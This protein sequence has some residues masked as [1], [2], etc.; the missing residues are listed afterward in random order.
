VEVSSNAAGVHWDLTRIAVDAADVRRRL[1]LLRVQAERFADRYRG[2]IAGL[3][4]AEL[5]RALDALSALEE[6]SSEI[7]GYAGLREAADFEDTEAA[8][9]AVALEEANVWLLAAT[10][11]VGL[12]W[13]AVP[14][15]E[16][17]LTA[18]HPALSRYRYWLLA[19]RRFAP[20]TL[21]KAEERVFEER[22]AS[23]QSAW[24]TLHGR[25][26]AGIE[27]EFDAGEGP[28]LHTLDLL[29]SY[30]H[31]PDR[32]LRR[33]AHEAMWESLVPR[34]D[35]L[36]A[37]YDAIVADRL[38]ADRLRGRRDPML[39]AHL[40]NQLDGAAVEQMMQAVE[41]RYPLAHRWWDSKAKLLGFERLAFTDQAAPLGRARKVYFAE[42]REL[43]VDA[44]A[45]LGEEPR[46]FAERIFTE[47]RIDAEPRAGK[48]GG[49]FCADISARLE[50][51][52]LTNHTDEMNDV[53][54]LAHE[55]GHALHFALA[56]A[57]QTPLT[58]ITGIALSEVPSTFA[59]LLVFDLAMKREKDE[60][61]R[62]AMLVDRVE[63]TFAAI[64]RQ[65]VMVRFEQ[66]AYALR[67]DSKTLTV[68]RL[69]DA[70]LETNRPYYGE[71]VELPGGS[72]LSWSYVPHFIDTRFYTYAYA[73]AH[74][75]AL[76][77]HRRLKLEGQP[78]VDRYITFLVS[79]DTAKPA[80]LLAPLG[81]QLDDPRTWT[82][83][84]DEVERFVDEAEAAFGL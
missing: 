55:L 52:V 26:V 30:F 82:T 62:K 79:G 59:E 18:D 6:E 34:A 21:S 45:V 47:R 80:D 51:Y 70:W 64:F 58:S 53:T 9:L 13:F 81:I 60:E 49:A 54:T 4:P 67:A 5:V 25:Q 29:A 12:E 83:G 14:Q 44:F 72:G 61:T 63:N 10:R 15:A 1:G 71:R 22:D 39:E 20:Y 77:L 78:F 37:C 35:V 3:E 17:E 31:S 56:Q 65:T 50:P 57:V 23:A 68:D 7:Q 69:T 16:A 46:L 38:A 28:E 76:N 84:L 41:A 24:A 43:A 11:F 75:I 74:L 2:R 66:R 73:W 8:D 40:D 32:I 27:V 19:I 42:A 48:A 36:A 33:R